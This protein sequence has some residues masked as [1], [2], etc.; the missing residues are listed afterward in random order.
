MELKQRPWYDCFHFDNGDILA[1]LHCS[2]SMLTIISIHKIGKLFLTGYDSKFYF[3]LFRP[4]VLCG[5]HCSL[6]LFY[7]YINS[8]IGSI[9]MKPGMKAHACKPTI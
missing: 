6:P 2:N 4:E 8:A 5:M 9:E 7:E 3:R 1:S